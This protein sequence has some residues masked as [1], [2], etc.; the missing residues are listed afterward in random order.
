M[1]ESDE[2]GDVIMV[3]RHSQPDENSVTVLGLILVLVAAIL[4]IGYLGYEKVSHSKIPAPGAQQKQK[5]GMIANDIVGTSD[6]IT[7][8]RGHFWISCG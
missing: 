1:H 5:Q 7:D 6:L 2:N 8:P 3:N 4:V